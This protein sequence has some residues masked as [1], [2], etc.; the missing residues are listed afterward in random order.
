MSAAHPPTFTLRHRDPSGPFAIEATV[1]AITLTLAAGTL[2]DADKGAFPLEGLELAM[3]P[4]N[5]RL[6]PIAVRN[7]GVLTEFQ[8][9]GLIDAVSS[10]LYIVDSPVSPTFKE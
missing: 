10:A 7:P 4:V 8:Q 9:E 6:E 5:G 3:H 1:G 2:H